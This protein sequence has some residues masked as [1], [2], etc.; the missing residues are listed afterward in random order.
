MSLRVARAERVL[1]IELS[2]ADIADVFQRLGLPFTR[3]EGA[4]GE[5]FTVTPPTYRFDI[6]IEEDLI[7]EVA[8]IYGFERIPDAAADRRERDAS[9]QRGTPLYPRGASRAGRPRLPGGDQLRLR[10]SRSGS[11][12]SPATT[13]RS[14][15]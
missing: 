5:V 2:T 9:D 14:A 7:E 15:C 11:A 8:R 13:T 12:T 10:G 1:G 3:S 4:E 6:E